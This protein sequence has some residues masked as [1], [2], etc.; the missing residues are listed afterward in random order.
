MLCTSFPPGKVADTASTYK[1][2]MQLKGDDS[3]VVRLGD[4]PEEELSGE[5]SGVDVSMNDSKV[6]STEEENLTSQSHGGDVP[7]QAAASDDAV[8]LEQSPP[9]E[10]VEEGSEAKE[11]LSQEETGPEEA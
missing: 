6:P 7:T 9:Q 8:V 10:V 4:E 11:E 3:G 2:K 5:Y 1:Y